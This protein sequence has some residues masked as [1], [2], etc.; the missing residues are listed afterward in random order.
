M[1]AILAAAI[2]SLA[3]MATASPL[4]GRAGTTDNGTTVYSVNYDK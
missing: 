2:V 1:H 3:A 4:Q